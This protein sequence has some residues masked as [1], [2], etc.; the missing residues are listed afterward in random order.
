MDRSSVAI[1]VPAWNE[2]KTIK[3]VVESLRNKA[4]VIV[5]DDC[6]T[7]MTAN[8]AQ[9]AGAIVVHHKNNQG[10][11]G[12]LNSGFDKVFELGIP[13]AITFDADGQH[14]PESIDLL[15]KALEEG[16]DL[17]LGV[18]PKKARIAETLIGLYFRMRFG[19]KDIL[20]GV[21]AYNMDLYRKNNGFDHINSIGAELSFNSL[22]TGVKFKQVPIN[23]IKREGESR[24]GNSISGNI[25]IAKA[26]FKIIKM[27]LTPATN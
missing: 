4:L 12:A 2:E 17:V 15:I 26:L 16:Y 25:K 27:D 8:C 9:T 7:D 23:V 11:D 24:F 18:R 5:V 22:K 19:V 6:S 21:K 13:Y 10:Y 20:C 3:Q 14:L 1:V